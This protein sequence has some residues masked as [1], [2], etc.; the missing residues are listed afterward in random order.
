LSVKKADRHELKAM[1]LELLRRKYHRGIP[2]H[3]DFCSESSP[4]Q[5]GRIADARHVLMP[6]KQPVLLTIWV[7]HHLATLLRRSC[8]G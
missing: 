3:D 1:L 4:Q 7:T 8:R 6:P 5:L 2:R